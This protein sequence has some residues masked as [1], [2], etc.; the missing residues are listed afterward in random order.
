MMLRAFC[1]SAEYFYT[2]KS[3]ETQTVF[4]SSKYEHVSSQFF[5]AGKS[6][7]TQTKEF[8]SS[9]EATESSMFTDGQEHFITLYFIA[10]KDFL[11]RISFKEQAVNVISSLIKDICDNDKEQGDGQIQRPSR[12]NSSDYVSIIEAYKKTLCTLGIAPGSFNDIYLY[13][14][15]AKVLDPNVFSITFVTKIPNKTNMFSIP[16]D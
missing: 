14:N 6:L 16:R 10:P 11:Y 15:S 1:N 12:R 5:S 7:N 13:I 3:E 8:R 4:K 9:Y 2:N